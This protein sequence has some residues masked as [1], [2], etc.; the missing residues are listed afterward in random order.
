MY[1]GA[2]RGT[3]PRARARTSHE[4]ARPPAP[5]RLAARARA[6]GNMARDIITALGQLNYDLFP[7][8]RQLLHLIKGDIIMLQKF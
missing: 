5:G 6:R 4:S 7:F 3:Q 8:Y 2:G 1:V